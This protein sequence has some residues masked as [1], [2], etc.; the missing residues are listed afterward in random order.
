MTYATQKKVPRKK[1]VRIS[2]RGS[3]E[4]SIA[5][6]SGTVLPPIKPFTN[7]EPLLPS[8]RKKQV[9]KLKLANLVN[10][11]PEEEE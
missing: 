8:L 3:S 1:M 6:V 4:E 2:T 11:A 9:V 10:E 7:Y 5:L